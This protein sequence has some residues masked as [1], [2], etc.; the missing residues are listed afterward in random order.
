MDKAIIRK[1]TRETLEKADKPGEFTEGLQEL[2]RS[3]IDREATRNYKRIIPN[4]GRFYGV[5]KPVLWIIATEIGRFIQ[6]EP[7]R[8][9]GLLE[10]TWDHYRR[11]F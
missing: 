5:P 1:R 6:K 4:T 8:A 2:L 11:L 9:Q 7:E 3:L 10:T